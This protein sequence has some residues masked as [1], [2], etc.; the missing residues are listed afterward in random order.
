M[1]QNPVGCWVNSSKKLC[2]GCA[3][4]TVVVAMKHS[5][6]RPESSGRCHGMPQGTEIAEIT[7][8]KCTSESAGL[9]YVD[10]SPMEP[11]HDATHPR[12]FSRSSRRLQQ[13]DVDG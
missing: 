2:R 12:P 3:R 7:Q 5:F 9:V 8:R 4:S 10:T 1:N 13:P 6:G 11:C